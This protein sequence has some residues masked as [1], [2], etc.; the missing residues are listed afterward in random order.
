MIITTKPR[1]VL[2]HGRR[3][4]H[5]FQTHASNNK[6]ASRETG[7]NQANCFTNR[8]AWRKKVESGKGRRR[9]RR[10]IGNIKIRKGDIDKD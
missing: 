4:R 6:I 3:N 7:K 10:R 9:R 5:T 8:S 1:F 2:G